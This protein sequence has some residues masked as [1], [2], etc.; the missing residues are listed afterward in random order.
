MLLLEEHDDID[1]LFTDL[2]MPH[3]NGIV[4]AA[5]G[6]KRRPGLRVIFGSGFTAAATAGS[7]G[8]DPDETFIAKPYRKTDLAKKLRGVLNRRETAWSSA[9]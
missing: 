9:Q 7:Q 5:E 6:R 1:V 8:L 4:L 2:A 3:M